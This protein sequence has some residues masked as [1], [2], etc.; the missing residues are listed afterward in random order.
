MADWKH[1]TVQVQDLD[2]L[3]E[4]RGVGADSGPALMVRDP[5]TDEEHGED[6]H[7]L[8][9]D[10]FADDP[11]YHFDPC[12]DDYKFSLDPGDTP[13]GNG[14]REIGIA[15]VGFTLLRNFAAAVGASFLDPNDYDMEAV[16]AAT[17]DIVAAL[18]E[19]L[20]AGPPA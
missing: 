19:C 1:P 18:N 10:C 15:H 6:G 5:D 20:E 14:R 16:K 12:G 2:F 7:F 3:V 8:R 17:P 4:W 11:H 9:F 13:P